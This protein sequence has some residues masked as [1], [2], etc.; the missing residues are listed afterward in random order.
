MFFQ[1]LLLDLLS[2]IYGIKILENKNEIWIIGQ[3]KVKIAC[4]LHKSKPNQKTSVSSYML[5]TIWTNM[6]QFS[7]LIER[8]NKTENTFSQLTT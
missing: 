7:I 5:T 4:P 8:I 6:Q 1:H 2:K 3:L